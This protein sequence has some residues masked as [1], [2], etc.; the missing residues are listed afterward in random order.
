M[1]TNM[2]TYCSV[3][4]P[5]L[6]FKLLNCSVLAS[7]SI[8]LNSITMLGSGVREPRPYIK[9][10]AVPPIPGLYFSLW[11]TSRRSKA[12]LNHLIV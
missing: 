10:D 9:V 1:S 4:A 8:A 5:Q 11:E 7:E 2:L 6:R 3:L 12:H